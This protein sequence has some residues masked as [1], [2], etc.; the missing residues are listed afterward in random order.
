MAA[1]HTPG[2]NARLK[3]RA[4][5]K[6]RRSIR[7]SRCVGGGETFVGF[8]VCQSAQTSLPRA[9]AR[10]QR[11]GLPKSQEARS[12]LAKQLAWGNMKLRDRTNRIR[13]CVVISIADS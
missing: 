7:H 9:L 4:I 12:P 13:L 3:T 2:Q 10:L 5:P 11:L 6:P 8:S 1:A